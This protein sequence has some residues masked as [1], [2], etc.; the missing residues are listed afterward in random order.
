MFVQ[1]QIIPSPSPPNRGDR[2]KFWK[3]PLKGTVLCF[4]GMVRTSFL[5]LRGTNSKTIYQLTNDWH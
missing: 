5:T 3:E 4:V 2:F 1:D